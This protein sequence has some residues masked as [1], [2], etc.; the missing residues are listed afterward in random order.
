MSKYASELIGTFF[1]VLV[2]GLTAVAPNGVGPLAPLAIGVTLMALVHAGHLSGAHYN[3]AVTL[4]I[5]MRGRLETRH[6]GPYIVAQVVAALLAAV[7]VAALEDMDGVESMTLAIPEALLAEAL[8]TFLLVFVILNVATSKWTEDNSYYGIAIGF[9]VTGGA[10]A[11][12]DVSGAA[13]NPAVAIAFGIMETAAWSDLWVFG[14]GE[15][16]GAAAAALAFTSMNP[17][18]P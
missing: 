5:W 16:A 1:L 2:I 14:I 13:F 15:F 18:D 11:V 12:G 10:Y 3:P 17:D 8:F 9:T 7:T 6:I 4:A